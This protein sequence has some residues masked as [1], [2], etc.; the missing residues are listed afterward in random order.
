MTLQGAVTFLSLFGP[1]AFGFLVFRRM[2]R[3]WLRAFI[4][5]LYIFVVCMFV[6]FGLLVLHLGV[7]LFGDSPLFALPFLVIACLWVLM[8]PHRGSR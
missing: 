1:P 6:L 2:G 5:A 7:G 8:A 4:D 3:P